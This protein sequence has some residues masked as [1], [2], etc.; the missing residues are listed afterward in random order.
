MKQE[1][2]E[3]SI[4]FTYEAGSA[5]E[6]AKMFLASITQSD[7]FVD[8]K[9]AKTGEKFTVDTEDLSAEPRY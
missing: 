1:L 4:S 5:E 2:F 6:A 8:V 3:C 9:N 7:W